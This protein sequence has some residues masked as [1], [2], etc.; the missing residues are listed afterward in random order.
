MHNDFY[1]SLTTGCIQLDSL[2]SIFNALYSKSIGGNFLDQSVNLIKDRNRLS[3]EIERK[4]KVLPL[5]DH[6][7]FEGMEDCRQLIDPSKIF[8]NQIKI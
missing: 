8:P 5:A 3:V 2:F 6:L 1:N 4:F 7:E